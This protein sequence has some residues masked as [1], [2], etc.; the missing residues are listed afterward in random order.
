MSAFAEKDSESNMSGYAGEVIS[1]ATR[2]MASYNQDGRLCTQRAFSPW[3]A[4]G[5]CFGPLNAG[6]RVSKA[7]NRNRSGVLTEGSWNALS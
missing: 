5:L 6:A 2:G 4:R 7:R 1:V 3:I